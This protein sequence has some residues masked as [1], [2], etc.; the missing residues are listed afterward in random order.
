LSCEG[1]LTLVSESF[2]A[3][4]ARKS[5]QE[6]F[7]PLAVELGGEKRDARRVAAGLGQRAHE[8][9]A[10]HVVGQGEDR[11]LGDRP[12]R[13]ANRRVSTDPNYV[14]AGFR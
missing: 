11:D 14:D 12:L 5:L 7:L 8:P 1:L 6:N 3:A 10:N 4:S 9:L 13:G 2:D